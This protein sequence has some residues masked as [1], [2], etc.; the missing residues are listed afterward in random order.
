MIKLMRDCAHNYPWVLKTIMG[1][2]AAAFVITM[3]WWGF[4]EKES[5]AVA[6][7]GDMQISREEYLRVYQNMYRFYKDN[8]PGEFK[9]DTIKQFAIE[10]L[11][12]NRLWALA[13]KDL[14]VSV[15]KDELRDAILKRGDF[16]RNGQ[17]DSDLYRQILAANRM[18]PA[19]FE[20]V[21]SAELLSSKAMTVIR[22]AVALTPGEIA[23]AQSLT[24]R[25]AQ[26]S[27][28]VAAQERILQD[29][30]AQKQQ[31]ALAAFKEA[32]K[33]KVPIEIKKELL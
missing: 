11:V 23:E 27:G 33:A 13:A 17:F 30:L 20:A 15:A 9:E 14:G 28:G 32:M 26:P 19:V 5:N 29:Y 3:G 31:R 12:E 2:L 6:S 22:D 24:A 18:T 16:Q 7:V 25:Q 10:G 21:F 8:I 1:V 4:D